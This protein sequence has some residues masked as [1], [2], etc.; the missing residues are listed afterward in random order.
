MNQHTDSTNTAPEQHLISI[1]LPTY[2]GE[3]Y[4]A[5]SIASCMQQTH[6]Q[7]EVIV[8]DDCSRDSTPQVVRQFSDPRLHYVRNE[9]N[10]GIAGALNRGFSLAQGAYVTWTSDDNYYDSCA[11]EEMLGFALRNNVEFV[12]ADMYEFNEEKPTDF[13]LRRTPEQFDPATGET[14]GACFIY[15]RR[16]MESVGAYEADCFLAEDYDYWI[17]ASRVC[18]FKHIPQPLYYYRQH[19]QSLTGQHLRTHAVLAASVL[20]RVKHDI[21]TPQ[22]AAHFV[23]ECFHFDIPRAGLRFASRVLRK[24]TLTA[25][26]LRE[27]YHR[28]QQRRLRTQLTGVFT[29]YRAGTMDMP[30]ARQTITELISQLHP[31]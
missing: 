12:Y 25:V 28:R 14:V 15:S 21:F 5:D 13:R 2:N 7:L 6:A 20:V 9:P 11:L 24:L 23:S 8:V 27:T 3:R 17:R 29:A 10:R 4:L 22:A 26:D 30:A 1:I 31:D 18:A 19:A 16:V